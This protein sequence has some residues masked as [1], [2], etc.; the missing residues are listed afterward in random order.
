MTLSTTIALLVLAAP[1][2]EVARALETPPGVVDGKTARALVEAGAV[3]V[4]V[5]TPQEFAAGHVP[6][7]KNIPFDQISARAAEI[8]GPETP[9]V[10]YCKTGRRSGIA[11][12]ALKGLGYEKLWDLQRV[13]RWNE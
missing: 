3:V 10:V 9:V 13:E 7:A 12:E 2:A 4:D 5:R 8:G 6:G 1:A 11:A